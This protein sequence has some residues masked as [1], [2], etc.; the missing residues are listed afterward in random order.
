M[1][2]VLL[3]QAKPL[4]IRG[5]SKS[6]PAPAG[7][8]VLLSLYVRTT[9]SD[10]C[11]AKRKSKVQQSKRVMLAAT[12]SD[13]LASNGCCEGDTCRFT[14]T[15]SVSV[16]SD[17]FDDDDDDKGDE[18]DSPPY[19][20]NADKYCAELASVLSLVH[21][22][23]SSEESLKAGNVPIGDTLL[24]AEKKGKNAQNQEMIICRKQFQR[25]IVEQH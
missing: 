22:H 1:R 13:A 7:E 21:T 9:A 24:V 15:P 23:T 8:L 2:C 18:E 6:A 3:I 4:A 16:P 17:A 19:K 11:I 20:R 14:R 5:A 12:A 25:N 10:Q